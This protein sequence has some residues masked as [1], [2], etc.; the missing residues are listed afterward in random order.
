[1]NKII[2]YVFGQFYWHQQSDQLTYKGSWKKDYFHGKGQLKYSNGTLFKGHFK[3]GSKTGFGE[4]VSP[5]GYNYQGD[6]I[7]GKK[8]GCAKIIYKN[9]DTYNGQVVDGLRQGLGELQIAASG[10]KFKGTWTKEKISGAV[11]ITT[12][13]WTFKGTMTKIDAPMTGKMLYADKST[14]VGELLNFQR[15]GQGTLTLSSGE[16]ISGVWND[17]VNVQDA[18]RTDSSGVYWE[19]SLRNLKPQGIM[20]IRLPNGQEYDGVWDSGDMLRVLSVH[21]REREPMPYIVH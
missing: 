11:E 6:W 14:Y 10:W 7:G 9:G 18:T 4:L 20:H 1:M 15:N 16:C 19:G 3:N 17:N 2:K 13:D 12:S 5:N 21:N 8:T